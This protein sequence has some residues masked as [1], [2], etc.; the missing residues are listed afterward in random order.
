[1][2]AEKTRIFTKTTTA[3]T[4]GFDINDPPLRLSNLSV[5]LTCVLIIGETC[6][7]LVMRQSPVVQFKCTY[8]LEQHSSVNDVKRNTGVIEI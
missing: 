2:P 1:M 6:R 7:H 3:N 4:K 5:E 8:G